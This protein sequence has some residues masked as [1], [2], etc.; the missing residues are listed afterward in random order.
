D[1]V[2]GVSGAVLRAA[3]RM[4]PDITGRS[5]VVYS[6]LEEV[7]HVPGPPDRQHPLLLC[8][9]RLV[10]DKGF[11]VAL[12]GFGLLAERFPHARLAIAGEGPQRGVLEAGEEALGVGD[13]VEFMGWL[14]SESLLTVM[15]SAS[16]VL[17][18]SRR[19]GLP[20]VAIQAAQMARPVIAADVGGLPE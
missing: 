19:E 12:R 13:R 16:V 4:V 15:E 10:H 20:L 11:D 1:W 8:V 2:S 6:G 9:G 17:M 18:P 3:Q 14:G 5:S 7:S